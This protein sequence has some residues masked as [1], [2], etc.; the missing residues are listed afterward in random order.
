MPSDVIFL[1]PHSAFF[2]STVGYLAF[3]VFVRFFRSVF[4][5]HPLSLSLSLALFLLYLLHPPV[6]LVLAGPRQIYVQL[7]FCIACPLYLRSMYIADLFF[8]LQF[9]FFLKKKS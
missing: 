9:F 4:L 5:C 2:F 3:F 7:A 1:F 6:R 8:T